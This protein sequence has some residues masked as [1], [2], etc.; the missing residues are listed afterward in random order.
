MVATWHH[1]RPPGPLRLRRVA[2]T[3]A[4]ATPTPPGCPF[5]RRTSLTRW[6]GCR[7]SSLAAMTRQPRPAPSL[8]WPA[9]LPQPASTT[10][11]SP[12]TTAART[13]PQRPSRASAAPAD[14][15]VARAPGAARNRR[16]SSRRHRGLL[17]AVGPADRRVGRARPAGAGR[18]PAAGRRSRPRAGL[19]S[20][21]GC[22]AAARARAA[23]WNRLVRR[24]LGVL[25]RDVDCPAKLVRRELLDRAELPS[26][27]GWSAPSSS[28]RRSA[29]MPGSPRSSYA[30][31][32]WP[33]CT[34]EAAIAPGAGSSGG[35]LAWQSPRSP[36][37]VAWAGSMSFAGQGYWDW[38]PTSAGRCHSSN[39][40]ATMPS[41]SFAWPPPGCP[42][43]RWR[44]LGSRRSAACPARC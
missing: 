37:P 7:S 35:S 38:G 10:R 31:S 3:F 18:L 27:A 24:V 23:I 17:D 14:V 9:P 41:P 29:W 33:G 39:S 32:P 8:L 22:P 44:A 13:R 5:P 26:A 36:W 42:P 16:R 4:T 21:A 11:S 30:S 15:S 1:C 40:R 25:V 34:T 12:S 6:P 43:G 28:P 2:P 20:D 19:A